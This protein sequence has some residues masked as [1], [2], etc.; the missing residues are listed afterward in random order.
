MRFEG[1]TTEEALEKAARELSRDAGQI[2]HRVVRDE[3]SFGG[4]RVVEIEVED[5]AAASGVAEA[6]REA[7]APAE[8]AT[9]PR[10]F[11]RGAAPEGA[12]DEEAWAAV[13]STL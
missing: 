6:P 12:T 1:R 8:P 4:G 7:P 10:P 11:E 2:R 13:E 9:E 3:K 5:E